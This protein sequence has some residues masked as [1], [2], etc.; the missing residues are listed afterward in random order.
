MIVQ[1]KQCKSW[2][3]G[4]WIVTNALNEYVVNIAALTGA[5]LSTGT[6]Y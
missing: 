4:R 1:R 5:S 6:D 2:N 3:E